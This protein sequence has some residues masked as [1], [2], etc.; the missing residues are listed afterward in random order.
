MGLFASL[1]AAAALLSTAAVQGPAFAVGDDAEPPSTLQV[2]SSNLTVNPAYGGRESF[3]VDVDVNVSVPDACAAEDGCK[4][5]LAWGC[6]SVSRGMYRT[7]YNT[8]TVSFTGSSYDYRY[9]D[10]WS[11]TG[12]QVPV[13]S[14]MALVDVQTPTWNSG[15]GTLRK[16]VLLDYGD[17]PISDFVDH[18]VEAIGAG[19]D[20][21]GQCANLDRDRALESACASAASTAG[22]QGAGLAWRMAAAILDAGGTTDDL[23]ALLG[24][25]YID[26][27]AG[28]PAGDEIVE[29]YDVDAIAARIE[30]EGGLAALAVL[31]DGIPSTNANGGS[32]NDLSELVMSAEE[33]GLTVRQTLQL[34]LDTVGAGVLV[35]LVAADVPVA[36]AHRTHPT[37]PAPQPHPIT[38]ATGGNP[39]APTIEYSPDEASVNEVLRS[40]YHRIWEGRLGNSTV[41]QNHEELLP[42]ES[43]RAVA[44]ECLQSAAA[45]AR[46]GATFDTANPC[47]EMRVLVPAGT[48]DGKVDL[49]LDAHAAALHDRDAIRARPEWFALNYMSTAAKRPQVPR[50]WYER[51]PYFAVSGCKS[52]LSSEQCDEYPLYATTQGG[53]LEDGGTGASL[54]PV[55]RKQ[56]SAEG[57][58][59]ATMVTT[60]VCQMESAAPVSRGARASGGT[61]FLV[62]PA[63]DLPI[64]SFFLC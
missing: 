31:A 54:R 11:L 12:C 47:R 34:L 33:S 39:H 29:G 51:A 17:F 48:G 19:Q 6:L 35:Y 18:L 52:R 20:Y 40:W 32:T 55:D 26:P 43:L 9:H 53:P 8:R 16:S 2:T 56:N 46:A 7:W 62:V 42:E 22:V 61:P 45:A 21:A 27:I 59:Y 4:L 60:G 14:R 50:Q 15:T 58:V 64:P 25:V 3:R 38:P 23:L 44:A 49:L 10:T 37:T 24:P 28:A 63:P 41:A 30:A 57:R 5:E 1:T 36:D 13:V